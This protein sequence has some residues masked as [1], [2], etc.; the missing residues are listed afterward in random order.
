[1]Q[2]LILGVEARKGSWK[3]KGEGVNIITS[4]FCTF[5]TEISIHVYLPKN[6]IP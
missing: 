2:D 5:Y 6:P 4:V 1:M 3:G